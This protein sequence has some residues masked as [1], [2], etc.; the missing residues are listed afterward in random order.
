MPIV[1]LE[2]VEEG[3]VNVAVSIE[4]GQLD[5]RLDLFFKQNRQHQD[6]IGSRRAE[7]GTDLHVVG[8]HIGDENALLLQGA[9]T[10]KALAGLEDVRDALTLAER[11][12]TQQ[13][14][15]W[16]SFSRIV[17]VEDACWAFT[18]GTSSDK[19]RLATVVKFF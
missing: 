15:E 18:S 10:D 3:D 7:A 8:R 4:R 16:L 5:H 19:I 6:V 17:D 9:L 1:L 13:L 11:V 14:Q 12:P 2:L